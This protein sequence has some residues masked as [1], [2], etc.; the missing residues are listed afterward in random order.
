MWPREPVAM[1]IPAEGQGGP[2]AAR[3]PA[4][5]QEIEARLREAELRRQQFHEWLACKA[6][7]KPRSPSW[8][9][10]EEDHAQ[11]LEAKLL[12]AEQKRLSLLAKAQDR[13][14]KLDELRQA[15]KNK[16]EMRFEKEREELETRVESRVRKAEENRLRLLHAGRRS[17]LHSRREQQGPW[18]GR[19]HQ[20]ANTWSRC[21]LLFC[22][23]AVLPRRNG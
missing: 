1:E 12:A 9:S 13:L 3:A 17:G 21:D 22:K 19:P 16:V 18:C 4:S 8:S 5:V 23:R 11:R 10:Q 6:R 15:A 20:R 14:A 7:K 2:A